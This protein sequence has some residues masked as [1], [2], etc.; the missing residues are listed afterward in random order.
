MARW[1]T[2]VPISKVDADK[3]IVSGWASIAFL[4]DGTQVIDSQGDSIDAD[5]LERAAANY[6]LDAR[7]VSSMHK[8]AG[9]GRPCSSIV[10]TPEVQAQMG[11]PPGTVPVGWW[12]SVKIDDPT[13]WA[14]VKSGRYSGFSIG[15]SGNR[16]KVG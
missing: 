11:I 10:F 1:Q 4:A 9:I 15:G 7:G 14:G 3:H 8:Q 13:V 16:Q 12:L 5:E 2:V 6:L